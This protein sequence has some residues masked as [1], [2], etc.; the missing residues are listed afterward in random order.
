MTLNPR[1]KAVGAGEALPN[2][3]EGYNGK[4]PDTGAYELGKSIPHYGQLW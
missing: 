1:G 4:S 3:N 2:I